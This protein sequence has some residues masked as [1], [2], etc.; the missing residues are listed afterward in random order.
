MP[1]FSDKLACQIDSVDLDNPSDIEGNWARLRQLHALP[2]SH[3]QFD[4]VFRSYDETANESQNQKWD[5]LPNFTQGYFSTKQAT[6]L[7][8]TN[9]FK[10]TQ[11]LMQFL[12]FVKQHLPKQQR[13]IGIGMLLTGR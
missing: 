13:W 8:K 4:V 6:T 9:M 5:P 11:Q 1:A 3:V 12:S 2:T 7:L 10:M